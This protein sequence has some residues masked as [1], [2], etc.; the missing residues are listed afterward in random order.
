VFW[1]SKKKQPEWP[2]AGLRETLFGDLPIERWS[3]PG[4]T[5]SAEEPWAAFARVREELR[6]DRA[7]AIASL[8][9]IANAR[10][11][12]PRH[13]LQAWHLLR[14]LGVQP[15]Q[16]VGKQVLG[17]VVEVP[18]EG[19]PDVLAAYADHSARYLN[20]AGGVVVWERPDDR[21]DRHIDALLAASSS[22]VQRIGPWDGPRPPPPRKDHARLNFLTP[23]GLH[24][25]EGPFGAL[26]GD[27][28][29]APVINAATL[30]MTELV[31]LGLK[32]PV[33]PS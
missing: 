13:H 33:G 31:E 7:A 20:H 11:F 14:E 16:D 12:E 2:L 17:V 23:S 5:P 15:D 32:K 9:S 27:P 4:N 1:N 21:L 8:Q 29:G 28:M 30:L 25:G 24:F 26:A 22:L 19:G 18:V 3:E 6:S 10:G